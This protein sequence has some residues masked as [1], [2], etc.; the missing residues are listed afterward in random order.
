MLAYVSKLGGLAN[1]WG[2]GGG[3][4]GLLWGRG[5]AR[6][7]VSVWRR[8]EPTVVG[9]HGGLVLMGISPAIGLV[10]ATG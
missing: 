5:F 2:S 6:V 8:Y 9:F 1:G 10:L 3:E 4:N 7:A